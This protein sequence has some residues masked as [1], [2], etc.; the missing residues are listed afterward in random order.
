MKPLFPDPALSLT[1]CERTISQVHREKPRKPVTAPRFLH[2]LQIIISAFHEFSCR[3]CF[4]FKRLSPG[5]GVKLQ[6]IRPY[7]V[8]G[9][10]G[11][12]VFGFP[13]ESTVLP[14]R[15]P[16]VRAADSAAGGR[17]ART[18]TQQGSG[19]GWEPRRRPRA[20][21]GAGAG[22]PAAIGCSSAGRRRDPAAGPPASPAPPQPPNAA[23][24]SSGGAGD[25]R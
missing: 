17:A 23:A 11:R 7:R 2:G 4:P 22:V 5:F 3:Q 14:S 19:P 13:R 12:R 24:R 9:E 18:R 25:R 1:V 8:G 10:R 16:Y 21:A 20:G 6:F 15:R